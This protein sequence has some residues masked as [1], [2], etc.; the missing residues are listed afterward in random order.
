M[1]SIR[2]SISSPIGFSSWLRTMLKEEVYTVWVDMDHRCWMT[3]DYLDPAFHFGWTYQLKNGGTEDLVIFAALSCFFHCK[4]YPCW[5]GWFWSD[6]SIFHINAAWQISDSI[7][8]ICSDKEAFR[9]AFKY[10]MLTIS[11]FST[12]KT[13]LFIENPQF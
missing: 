8:Y 10:F 5:Y 13:M 9:H 1:R 11:S 12:A 6:A 4:L 3:D 2:I 7:I